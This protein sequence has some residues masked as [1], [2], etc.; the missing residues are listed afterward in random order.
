MP[1]LF[2]GNR[3]MI[4]WRMVLLSIVSLLVIYHFAA[5]HFTRHKIRAHVSYL[6]HALTAALVLYWLFFI[7][8]PLVRS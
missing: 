1:G 6:L 3:I 8:V 5:P 2:L 7:L 4:K